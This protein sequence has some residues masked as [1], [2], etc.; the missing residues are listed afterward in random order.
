MAEAHRGKKH[1]AETKRKISETMK[2]R[3]AEKKRN[4]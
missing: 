4:I 1:S 2:K 3:H